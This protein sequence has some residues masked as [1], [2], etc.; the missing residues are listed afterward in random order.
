MSVNSTVSICELNTIHNWR[1][2]RVELEVR[3]QTA[4]VGVFGEASCPVQL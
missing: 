2:M 1:E 4:G 3:R